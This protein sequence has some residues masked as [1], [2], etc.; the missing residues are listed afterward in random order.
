MP[1]LTGRCIARK[2][3]GQ[4][5]HAKLHLGLRRW[6]PKEQAVRTLNLS[7]GVAGPF[8]DLVVASLKETN[9]REKLTLRRQA[10]SNPEHRFSRFQDKDWLVPVRRHV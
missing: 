6:P 10:I 5:L 7:P 4:I 3:A 1:A 9:R 2:S 8:V